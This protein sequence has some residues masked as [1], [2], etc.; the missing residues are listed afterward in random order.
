[1]MVRE[2]PSSEHTGRRDKV[3]R[4]TVVLAETVELGRMTQRSPH[5]RGL[6]M[7]GVSVTFE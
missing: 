5:L 3:S 2:G 4:C 6:S 1:M 7:R